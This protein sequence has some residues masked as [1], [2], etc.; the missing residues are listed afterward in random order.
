MAIK[1]KMH[2]SRIM[3]SKLRQAYLVYPFQNMLDI[4]ILQNQLH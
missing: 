1:K 3:N 4:L 2:I